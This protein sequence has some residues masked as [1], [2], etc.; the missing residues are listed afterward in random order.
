MRSADVSNGER[1]VNGE[2]IADAWSTLIISGL[3]ESPRNPSRLDGFRTSLAEALQLPPRA[4]AVKSIRS[5]SADMDNRIGEWRLRRPTLPI[6]VILLHTEREDKAKPEL[7]AATEKAYGAIMSGLLGGGAFLLFTRT[8]KPIERWTLRRVVESVGST[9]ADQLRTFYPDLES[10]QVTRDDSAAEENVPNPT[11][12]GGASPTGD[13]RPVWIELTLSGHEHGGPGWE[14][15]HC[16]WSP[17]RDSAGRNRYA[18]M[19]EPRKGDRVLH[20]LDSTLKGYSEVLSECV[21]IEKE[22]PSPGQWAGMPPYYRID[23]TNYR[24]VETEY[25]ISKL[26]E[27]YGAALREDLTLNKPPRYPFYQE[28]TGTLRTVQG[29][30]LTRCSKAL[31]R[32]LEREAGFLSPASVTGAPPLVGILPN[33]RYWTIAAGEGGRVW[34]IFKAESIISIGWDELGDLRRYHG[35]EALRAAL[36]AKRPDGANPVN[37]SLAC[38][39]FTHVMKPG[40]WVLAKRGTGEVLGV[41][42]IEGGYQYEAERDEYRNVRRVQWLAEGPWSLPADIRIPQKTLTDVT[43][44]TKL[45]DAVLPHVGSPAPEPPPEPTFSVDEALEGLFLD[46]EEFIGIIETMSR[47]RNVILEGPPRVGKTFIARRLAYALMG[48]KTPSRMEM[49]QFHQS[50]AYEDFVR[51]WR[52]TAAGG[53]ALI[54]GVFLKFCRRAAKDPTRRYVFII[55]EINRGNLSKIFGELMMLVEADKRGPEFAVPL[56]YTPDDAGPSEA[57][58]FVPENVYLLGMMN[59]ADRSLAMVDYALRR[60]FGFVRLRPAFASPK[61]RAFL[62]RRGV[63]ESLIDRI[64]DRMQTLNADIVSDT[65]NLGL[66]FEVGH[67]FFCPQGTEENC[68]P[69]WYVAVVR[70]EVEPLLREYWFDDPS[71]VEKVVASLLA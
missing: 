67:S 17:N 16:L 36:S 4:V 57:R 34:P 70:A 27:E 35:Q 58:F 12:V 21:E 30:Y 69:D 25:S 31:Y 63:A 28:H 62:E 50:Y 29:A 24:P 59:T 37:D 6:A 1:A 11:F 13:E 48:Y 43:S 40:D 54:D 5:V 3:R 41:G 47:K 32:I 44:V 53:F 15:G 51:G 68:G 60:R 42:I 18:I 52:P 56:A 19:R 55:D 9:V 38:H 45:L 65:K 39:Q 7:D 46:R 49:V 33:T 10:I 14:F 71:R 66:G 8:E 20:F 22:P 23:L 26:L 61:F 2:P 64:V